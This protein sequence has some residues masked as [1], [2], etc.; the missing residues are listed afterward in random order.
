[1]GVSIL[2]GRNGRLSEQNIPK[3][4]PLARPLSL[5]VLHLVSNYQRVGRDLFPPAPY[6]CVANHM[7]YFDGAVAASLVTESVPAFAAK[8]YQDKPFGKFM[9]VMFGVMWIEQSAPDLQALKR[10]LNV[11]KAGTPIAIAPEGTRSKTGALQKGLDGAAYI[12]HKADVPIVPVAIAGT[13]RIGKALRPKV[14]GRIGKPFRFESVKRPSKEQLQDD[15]DRL[16]CALAA[17][18]PEEHHGYYAGH[19]LI[20]EMA[21]IVC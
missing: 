3:F 1:M 13:N 19:P 5:A 8:K 14:V 17:L 10:G 11:L 12:I 18:L 6:I 4:H 9:E 21:K 16:M 2:S 15:T 7:S 20:E